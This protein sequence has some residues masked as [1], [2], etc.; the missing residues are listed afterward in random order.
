[1]CICTNTEQGV[2]NVKCS[3]EGFNQA[4]A[5]SLRIDSIGRDGKVVTRRLDC[6]DLVILRWFTDFYPDM[7]K[8]KANGREYAWLVAAKLAE[9]L[10]ILGI[11][12][13]AAAERL[14]KLAD[15]G[16]LDRIIVRDERGT[17]CLYGFGPLY[18][19]MVNASE[20]EPGEPEPIEETEPEEAATLPRSS[21][22][23]SHVQTLP[24][25]TSEQHPLPRSSSTPSHVQTWVKDKTI[26]NKTTRDKT[27][28]D[29][30]SPYSPPSAKT[31]D[32][33][34]DGFD[35][36]WAVYPRK[37]AK[38]RARKAWE[39]IRPDAE[40]TERIIQGAITAKARDTRFREERF[41]P[42]PAT[43]L[44]GAEWENEYGGT[45]NHGEQ[46]TYD[47]GGFRSADAFDFMRAPEEP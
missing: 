10:P 28:R 45:E 41:T 19:R 37:T 16:I 47:A 39:K 44:N 42:H 46:Q 36:F 26:I 2:R 43:W 22:T 12:K 17:F 23:P 1:M 24:P 8:E 5:A 7:K 40:L 6:I 15:F 33:P 34:D 9:D 35:R 14:Q 21:S 29:T 38:A 20:P 25:P 3:I 18:G 13:R 31:R 30:L 27:T 4:Y 32:A 11:T